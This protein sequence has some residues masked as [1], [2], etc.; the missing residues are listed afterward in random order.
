MEFPLLE[1]IVATVLL[2]SEKTELIALYDTNKAYRKLLNDPFVLGKITER[3]RTRIVNGERI[4]D[5]EFLRN[6]PVPLS[7]D[8]LLDWLDKVLYESENCDK[9][10]NP[11]RCELYA[12]DKD[13]FQQYQRIM[14]SFDVEPSEDAHLASVILVQKGDLKY[15][16]EAIKKHGWRLYYVFEQ[17]VLQNEHRLLT[18]LF[19][20][21]KE[22]LLRKNATS[23]TWLANILFQVQDI[24]AET[25]QILLEHMPFAAVFLSPN[26][27]RNFLSL[28]AY[29]QNVLEKIADNV[30]AD[31]KEKRRELI[32]NKLNEIS[33]Q[34]DDEEA[35]GM[36]YRI[37]NADAPPLDFLCRFVL[38][39]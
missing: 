38:F 39:S 9:Y 20:K 37:L 22:A 31:Y 33:V 11:L 14:D 34:L 29:A 23:N 3:V 36:L 27:K 12:L 19:D 1:D 13:N 16:N 28:L 26:I 35:K 8:E 24:D 30:I 17:S 10:H 18:Y 21:H 6:L 2:Y 7:F 32:E 4:G 15:I 5:F 25:L